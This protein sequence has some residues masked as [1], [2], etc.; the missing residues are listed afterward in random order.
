MF[1]DAAIATDAVAAIGWVAVA[2]YALLCLMAPGALVACSRLGRGLSA[3]ARLAAALV[4]SPAVLSCELAMSAF[5]GLPFDDFVRYVVPINLL[6][7]P[8]LIRVGDWKGRIVRALP[9]AIAALAL[10]LPLLPPYLELWYV[11]QYGWHNMMH[12]ASIEQI[13]QL[14]KIPEEMD[15]A[16]LRLNYNWLAYTQV[17]VLASATGRAPTLWTIPINIVQGF[18]LFAFLAAATRRLWAFTPWRASLLT[19]I[20]VMTPGLLDVLIAV[21]SAR[22][23]STG[24][25][26]ITPPT[27]IYI[28]LDAMVYGMASFGLL[29]YAITRTLSERHHRLLP[30]IPIAALSCGLMY[31]LM[32][33]ACL[34]VMTLWLLAASVSGW[35][36]VSSYDARTLARTVLLMLVAAAIVVGYLLFIGAS[37]ATRPVRLAGLSDLRRHA[38]DIALVFGPVFVLLAWMAP[39]WMRD[40]IGVPFVQ[41]VMFTALVTC[42]GIFVMPT[43]VEYKFLFAALFIVVPVLAGGLHVSRV[44]T[45]AYA[46]ALVVLV[47]IAVPIVWQWH[48]PPSRLATAVR[49]NE[50]TRSIC[51]DAGWESSWMRAV[52]EQTPADTVVLTGDTVEPVPVFTRRSLYVP[53]GEAERARNGYSMDRATILEGVKGYSPAEIAARLDVL[54]H[55][56]APETPDATLAADIARLVALRRPVALHATG[57]SALERLLQQRGVGHLIFQDNTGRVRLFRPE[58]LMD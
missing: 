9:L 22:Y 58:E 37:A 38:W 35:R 26:R 14:P 21:V 47:A 16:G 27:E 54:H 45:Q 18:A 44:S 57:P 10:L 36:R 46:A 28:N 55:A 52:R 43:G 53:D 3:D 51:P 40:G 12:L 7:L 11:R 42:F 19:G 15:L 29:G 17:A 23:G 48:T 2:G 30:M 56:L 50:T 5:C 24:E 25:G 39:R 41:A 8:L 49:L 4:L 20:A 34:V 32:F 1:F 13:Y 31:P 6:G 33:P